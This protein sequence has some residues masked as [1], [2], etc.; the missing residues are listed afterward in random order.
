MLTGDILR[1]SAEPHP[2]RIALIA[3]KTNITDKSLYTSA[4]EFANTLL[5]FAIGKG[6]CWAIMSQNR[7]E[8]VIAHFG[9]AQTG[10]IMM[11]LQPSYTSD[12]LVNILNLAS[13]RLIVVEETFQEKIAKI[14]SLI[15]K[16]EHVIV[17]GSPQRDSW[18]S[19]NRVIRTQ[20]ENALILDLSENDDF[21]M[22][23][24]GGTTGIPKG[25]LVSHRARLASFYT[26]FIEH[27]VTASDIVGIVT[28]FYHTMGSLVWLPA[29]LFVG[30]TAVLISSWDPD[31]FIEQ[32]EKQGISYTFMVPV[33]LRQIL[34]HNHFNS[35]KLKSLVNIAC[36][37]ATSPADL[38]R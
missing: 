28:P 36:G 25:R 14:I 8:Y 13:V 23:F 24:T 35:H 17:I 15:P 1:L 34:S 22:T 37:G 5:N 10:A 20:P 7:P 3:G 32:T 38:I 9:S 29:A 26:T 12:D 2:K 21:A 18:F 19:F 33:Q 30:A 11:N 31:T 27:G 4:N 6:V 16:L